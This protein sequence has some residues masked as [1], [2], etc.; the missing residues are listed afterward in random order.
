MASNILVLPV[1]GSATRMQG[2]PKFLLP[3]SQS[4]LLI[5]KHISGALNA[6]FDFVII[7]V[8]NLFFDLVSEHLIKYGDRVKLIRL[9]SET[10]TMAESLLSGLKGFDFKKTDRLV[11]GLSDTA[12]KVDSYHQLY[13]EIRHSKVALTLTLFPASPEQLGKLGQVLVGKDNAV[14]DIR[15]KDPF[16]KYPQFWGIASFQASFL[17]QIDKNDAHIGVSILRWLHEGHSVSA[18]VTQIQYFDCGTFAEYKRF[19]VD[20]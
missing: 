5:D 15:D 13:E 19:L 6:G 9:E 10:K 3:Y 11:V 18:L 4:E 8:K 1:G 7:I 16:C 17:R 20:I 2:L 12:L 14:L